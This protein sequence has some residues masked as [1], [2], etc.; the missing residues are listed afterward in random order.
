MFFLLIAVFILVVN[1]LFLKRRIAA[2]KQSQQSGS[3][4]YSHSLKSHYLYCFV[5]WALVIVLA[6]AFS[7][8]AFLQKIILLVVALLACSGATIFLFKKTFNAKKHLE[9]ITKFFLVA[10]TS[11]GVIITALITVSI[12]FEAVKFFE[13]VNPIQFLFGL[14]WNPQIAVHAEQGLSNSSFGIVPVFM[15]T[16]LITVVALTVAIPLGL[17]AAIYLAEY[18]RPQTRNFLKPILEMLAGVPTVVYGYFAV[19]MVAPFLKDFLGGFGVDVASE[20]ALSAGLVMGVMIIPFIL[21]LSEYRS[22][23]PEAS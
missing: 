3:S 1:F 20:S 5:L 21:S 16:L 2:T 18:A 22:S 12:V 13:T 14:S 8:L 4:F 7:N 11:F 19:I 15:G 10:S 23:L 6:T 17:M 9:N